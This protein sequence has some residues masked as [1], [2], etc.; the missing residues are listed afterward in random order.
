MK[1]DEPI[2][3][4]GV[5]TANPLGNE[6]AA[7]A[8]NLLAGKSGVRPITDY[9]LDAQFCKIAGQFGPLT[10]PT[11]WN[12]AEFA[13]LGKLHQL[14]LWCTTGALVDSGYWNER[15]NLR[16]GLVLGLGAEWPLAWERDAY[17]GGNN[18]WAPNGDEV[19]LIRSVQMQLGLQGPATVVAAACASGNVALA[20]GR[21]WLKRGWVD[22]CLAG[23]CDAWVTPLGLASFGRL[24]VLSRRNDDPAKA[25]R[26]FDKDRD[27]FVMGEGGA[28]F[29]L[30]TA[31]R[32]RRRSA[33]AYCELAGY[34]ATSDASN[35]VI[36]NADPDPAARAV[37][38]ALA[39]AEINPEQI[40]YVNAHG[41]GTPVGDACETKVLR[42]AL[43]TAS[44]RIPVS[45]TKSM[46][47]HLLS[48]AAALEALVCIVA[49]QRQAVPPTIN[50]DDPD[51]DCAL[52]HVPHQARP[53]PVRVAVSN[54]FGFGGNNT[55]VVLR[56]VA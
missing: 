37:R 49:L 28:M 3:V 33:H 9:K 54:S 56:K 8:G 51:P 29:V 25:S 35:L 16:V 39:D 12:A 40:D 48:A 24:R 22:V 47:G 31:E 38:G 44:D 5:G 21:N 10:A 4:T 23:A 1:R 32:A 27:G 34:G 45:S 41:T 7:V 36:P 20:Q 19:S 6:Y 18:V 13:Q 26:P 14:I 52:C 46:T 42:A 55:C 53:Q 15:A 11:G 43:S 17:Q 50:L 2:W 30:E